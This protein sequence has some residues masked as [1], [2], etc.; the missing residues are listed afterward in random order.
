[1]AQILANKVNPRTITN[2]YNNECRISEI[3]HVP[4][5]ALSVE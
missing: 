3:N 4:T 5:L 2:E 1:M